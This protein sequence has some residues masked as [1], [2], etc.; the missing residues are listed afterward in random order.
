MAVDTGIW[1]RVWSQEEKLNYHSTPMFMISAVKKEKIS[2]PRMM[3]WVILIADMTG[4]EI[5]RM[6]CCVLLRV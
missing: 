1:Q 5:W 2:G 6:P 4:K 3:E